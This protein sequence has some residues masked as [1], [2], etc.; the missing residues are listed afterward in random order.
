[1]PKGNADPKRIEDIQINRPSS[2]FWIETKPDHSWL[3]LLI[4][5]FLIFLLL[6]SEVDKMLVMFI[7][8]SILTPINV[9]INQKILS[10]LIPEVKIV[11]L[12]CSCLQKFQHTHVEISFAMI[13]F[14]VNDDIYSW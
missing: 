9:L 1:M 4:L 6:D 7:V 10:N 3:F 13:S 12:T 11:V 5:S 8:V 14:T 2:L